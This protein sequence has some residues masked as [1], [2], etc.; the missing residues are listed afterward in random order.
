VKIALVSEGTYPFAMGGVSVWCDQL[1]RGMPEC[2]W[3]MVALTVDGTE[4]PVWDLPDNLDRV[5]VIPLWGPAPAGRRQP[6][7]P[8]AAFDVA[9][10]TFL[11][12][13]LTPLHPRSEQAAA[14]RSEF[15][16]ALRGLYEYAA[17]GGDIGAALAS[18]HALTLMM[19][20]WND[21]HDD[22]LTLADALDGAWLIGHMLRPL[23]ARPV[24]ADI[25]HASMNGLSMLVAMAAKWRYRTPVVFG[26]T[27]AGNEAYRDSCVRLIED[28]GLTGAA[29]LEGRVDTPVRA[30]H[31]GSVVA[32]TSISEGFPYTV[33]EA[34][35]CGR[36][37]VC[38]NVGGSRRRWPTPASSCRR[39][40]A[41]RWPKPAS[42]CCATT[43][44]GSAG[45]R[46][47]APA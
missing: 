18:N 32:L 21:L 45:R 11:H 6:G 37:V 31:A 1:I 15:L 16:L 40:T 9:Y 29:A 5:R 14:Y 23:A 27:P 13:L 8:G 41:R 30:Y 39:A 43:R 33:V 47:P 44:C 25:V 34:M 4:R 26:N 24:Q 2:R 10:Q 36:T 17:T 22:R 12:A 20:A 46:P 7:R 35:A 38:T 28:L 42:G 19:D 3:E